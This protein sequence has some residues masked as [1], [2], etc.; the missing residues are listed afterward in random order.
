M[1]GTSDMLS[2]LFKMIEELPSL[3]GDPQDV[4]KWL[5]YKNDFQYLF[6]FQAAIEQDPY[7]SLALQ[8]EAGEKDFSFTALMNQI[9]KK[10]ALLVEAKQSIGSINRQLQKE[11]A[12][13]L[14]HKLVKKQAELAAISP[15][16]VIRIQDALVAEYVNNEQKQQT[17]SLTARATLAKLKLRDH[18]ES[19][20]SKYET[21]YVNISLTEQLAFLREVKR[22]TPE[23]TFVV[24]FFELKETIQNY[25]RDIQ[26]PESIIIASDD[27]AVIIKNS[28]K[29]QKLNQQQLQDYYDKISIWCDLFQQ[30]GNSSS[31]VYVIAPLVDALCVS[32]KDILLDEIEASHSSR[33]AEEKENMAGPKITALDNDIIRVTRQ[34]SENKTTP[35]SYSPEVLKLKKL[36]GSPAVIQR[37][38]HLKDPATYRALCVDTT[39]EMD[40]TAQQVITTAWNDSNV[41]DAYK[42]IPSQPGVMIEQC[43]PNNADA[44]IKDIAKKPS[45]K[46]A[47]EK[48][49]SLQIIIE[50]YQAMKTMHGSLTD[51]T[52]QQPQRLTNFR[53]DFVRALPTLIKNRD[54]KTMR[55]MKV[56][57]AIVGAT[58]LLVPTLGIGSYF[59]AKRIL[60]S[61]SLK[62]VDKTDKQTKKYRQIN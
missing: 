55:F 13:E 6:A 59:F 36:A 62:Y 58:L 21:P 27:L 46:R 4:S 31:S 18:T 54:S 32:L 40:R 12:V 14:K 22:Q 16:E 15:F 5:P 25:Q 53:N 51:Q 61:T 56:A 10:T 52:K 28:F 44:L 2:K 42:R 45:L 11:K 20:E 57:G 1:T 50:K 29:K 43:T 30:V 23:A 34:I 9:N 49:R 37:L 60:T 26:N 7:L 3:S 8:I 19:K 41:R 35:V 39:I 17:L 47:I 38:R 33:T 24:N 48:N